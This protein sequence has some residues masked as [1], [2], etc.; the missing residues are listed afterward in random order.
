MKPFR[1]MF[2]FFLLWL[3]TF[4]HAGE[5]PK[6]Y[7]NSV[8]PSAE[9][10]PIPTGNGTMG[11]MMGAASF[12][13]GTVVGIIYESGAIAF[14]YDGASTPFKTIGTTAGIPTGLTEVPDDLYPGSICISDGDDLLFCDFDGNEIEKIDTVY[15][16]EDITYDIQ[17]D[18][19]IIATENGGLRTYKDGSSSYLH[20]TNTGN[21]SHLVH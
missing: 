17:R 7:V 3:M 12:F 1:S 15:V 6:P 13:N 20:A 11:K 5:D 4:A 18:R 19:F 10:I 21:R 14:F 8:M 2:V 9:Y 16:F